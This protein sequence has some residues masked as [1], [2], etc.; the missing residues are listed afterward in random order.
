[1]PCAPTGSNRRERERE[2][3]RCGMTIQLYE[4]NKQEIWGRINLVFSFDTTWT[5]KKMGEK[6]W[7]G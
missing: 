4:T 5:A 2:R 3:E 6:N 1:M 7:G